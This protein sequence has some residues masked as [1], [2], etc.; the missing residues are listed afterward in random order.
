MFA[1]P[2]DKLSDKPGLAAGGRLIGEA[3]L[4]RCDEKPLVNVEAPKAAP[5]AF[6]KASSAL[7]APPGSHVWRSHGAAGSAL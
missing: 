7:T 4:G 1:L 6:R 3:P 2:N 5:T